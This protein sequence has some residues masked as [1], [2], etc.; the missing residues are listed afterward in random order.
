MECSL[1]EAKIDATNGLPLGDGVYAM[2]SEFAHLGEQLEKKGVEVISSDM[3]ETNHLTGGGMRCSH[4]VL[5]RE[6]D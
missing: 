4:A 5:V 6:D 1:D 3:R 2:S